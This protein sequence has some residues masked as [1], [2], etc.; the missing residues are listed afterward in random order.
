MYGDVK[1]LLEKPELVA[2]T[3]EPGECDLLLPY[4]PP[5]PSMLQLSTAPAARRSRQ[6]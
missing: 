6:G 3:A 4:Q 2:D 5:K 1:V